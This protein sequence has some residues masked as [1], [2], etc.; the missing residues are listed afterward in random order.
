MLGPGMPTASAHDELVAATPVDGASV[1]T[2]PADV[3]LQSSGVVQELGAQVAVTGP[4][5]TVVGRGRPQVVDSVLTQPLSPDLPAG[6]YT[7][8]WRVTSA[9]GHPISGTTSF[10]VGA[11]TVTGATAPVSEAAAA[12]PADSSSGGWIGIGAGAVLLL[13]LVGA[14]RQLRGRA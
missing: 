4:D 8:A 3:E 1:T 6:T 7:V 5:G 9:D 12:R 10:T 14:A 11:G 13:A 2:A